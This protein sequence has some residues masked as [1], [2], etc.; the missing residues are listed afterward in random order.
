[1][2]QEVN[3]MASMVVA[4][5]LVGGGGEGNEEERRHTQCGDTVVNNFPRYRSTNNMTCE[6][7]QV[8]YPLML[9]M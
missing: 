1:M 6:K 7:F 3:G 4:V 9:L 8:V 2:G 5:A